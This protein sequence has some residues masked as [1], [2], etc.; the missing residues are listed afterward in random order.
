MFI[1]ESMYAFVPFL[2]FC[3]LQK[4]EIDGMDILNKVLKYRMLLREILINIFYLSIKTNVN[5]TL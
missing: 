2:C 4:L 5:I 1:V 3:T